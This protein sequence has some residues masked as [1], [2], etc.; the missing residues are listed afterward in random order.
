MATAASCVAVAC[1]GRRCGVTGTSWSALAGPIPTLRADGTMFRQIPGLQEPPRGSLA[2]VGADLGRGLAAA[3]RCAE[4]GPVVGESCPGRSLQQVSRRTGPKSGAG[5]VRRFHI[6]N[7]ALKV[8]TVASLGASS[9]EFGAEVGVI[10]DVG[11]LYVSP[12]YVRR[13]ARRPVS[14]ATL[15]RSAGLV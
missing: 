3:T 11:A 1:F 4:T 10:C 14:L 2:L 12:N 6:R 7:W 8:R 15:A 5:V 13:L 9:S